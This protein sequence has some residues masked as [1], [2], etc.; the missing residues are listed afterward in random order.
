MPPGPEG[1]VVILMA[2]NFDILMMHP[3]LER[4]WNKPMSAFL[5]KK[6]YREIEK[7][8][9]P[10]PH[11]PGVI[12]LRTGKVTEAEANAVL[13]D[14][15]VVPFV[16]RAYPVRGVDGKA[17][18]WVEVV[19]NVAG[20]KQDEQ[21]ARSQARLVTALLETSSESRVLGLGLEAALQLQGARCGCAVLADD[22]GRP[23][24]VAQRGLGEAEAREIVPGVI[25]GH[26]LAIKRGSSLD[27]CVPVTYRG[28]PMAALIVRLP[29]NS[30]V[31]TDCWV[32][33][34]ALASILASAV[35]RLWSD[36]LRGDSARNTETIVSAN[37][38]P[39]FCLDARCRLTAW[40]KAC[41]Q[42][43]GWK[44]SEVIGR[45]PPFLVSA[46]QVD[47]FL[48]R[49]NEEASKE[50]SAFLFPCT[51]TKGIEPTHLWFKAVQLR[52]VI[53]DGTIYAVF[54]GASTPAGSD[55]RLQLLADRIVQWIER[56][57]IRTFSRSDCYQA[58]RR[59]RGVHEPA[60]IVPALDM[61]VAQ[62]RIRKLPPEAA[63]RAGRPST[64]RYDV[65]DLVGQSAQA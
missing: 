60:D 44:R 5:G 53:Q 32:K 63:S 20:R 59:T 4:M 45:I 18:G 58:L 6:C 38:S 41:E 8:Q 33:L 40:N 54:V 57:G 43:F 24:L 26:T 34:E 39:L 13:D 23:Q 19:E 25:E 51:M 11:C 1:E 17:A 15:T 52:D 64:P 21:H 46:G 48:T 56:T 35:A 7:R 49:V 14:G 36:R 29:A 50:A 37:L 16:L 28:R 31:W 12:A 65:I 2:P 62:S 27:V 42:F 9:D 30:A 55:P 22:H 10:C 3:G 47:D 61:L